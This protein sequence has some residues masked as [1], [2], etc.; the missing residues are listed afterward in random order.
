[1]ARMRYIKPSFWTDSKIVDLSFAARLFFIGMWNFA[2]CGE[3]HL[4]DDPRALKRL[5]LPDDDVV[6]ET[7]IDELVDAGVVAR[8]Q[9]LSGRKFLHIV[10]FADH[11]KVEKRWSPTCFVCTETRPLSSNHDEPLPTSTKHSNKSEEVTQEGKGGEGK[12]KTS[13]TA[14]PST[15]DDPAFARF[16]AAYPRKVGKGEARKAWAK[17]VKSGVDPALVIAGAERYRDDP[18]RRRK[19][20]EYTKH[21][22]P[23]LNAE[24]WTDQL[25]GNDLPATATGWWDN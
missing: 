12:K 15:G 23:W 9:T 3:G 19:D 4:P 1:M 16:W 14:S 21:P 25:N 22:G 13:S 7:V 11:Q 24:R 18:M 17:V 5:I 2:D 6:G 20:I 8:L 10:R